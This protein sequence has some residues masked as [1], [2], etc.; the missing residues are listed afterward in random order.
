MS[1][2]ICFAYRNAFGPDALMP[3]QAEIFN[4]LRQAGLRPVVSVGA[5]Q[6]FRDGAVEAFEPDN[7]AGLK[8]DLGLLALHSEV[9]VVVNR[10]GRTIKTEALPATIN[11]GPVRSL[12]HRKWKAHRQILE[13]VGIAMPTQLV[14]SQAEAKAF[15]DQVE[16]AEFVAKPQIGRFGAGVQRVD[17]QQAAGLFET[18][19]DWYGNY[20]LQPAYDLSGPFPATIEAYDDTA[21]R[22]LFNECNDSGQPKELRM[23]GFRDP[24]KT[25]VY[26]VGRI[27][28]GSDTWFFVQPET[29]PVHLYEKT[30]EAME[31][32]ASLTGAA[33][34][35]GSVDFGYGSYDGSEPHW[36]AVEM[37][38][39]SPYMVSKDK[40]P[41]V[42]A[43]LR[44]LMVEQVRATAEAAQAL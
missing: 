1:A 36:A 28:N 37:N 18:N 26:P 5:E 9:S 6:A 14:T 7:T 40:H 38:L 24:Y 23:Y 4:E 34:V 2:D 13:P 8:R 11:E 27:V 44:G 39:R 29:V 42:A 32:T 43:D 22:Q 35:Y 33:A 30:T 19:G 31:L 21:S 3:D 10:V 25:G 20:L 12:G 41:V 17:R 16:A 15:I